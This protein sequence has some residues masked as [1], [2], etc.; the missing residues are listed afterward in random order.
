MNIT[1]RTDKTTIP[2]FL[3]LSFRPFFLGGALFSA[4]AIMWWALYFSA[5]IPSSALNT[6]HP[7]G[8]AIW[9]HGHEM[10]FGFG[11]AIIAGFL[12]TAVQTWTRVP[13]IKGSLL[14]ALFA[15]WLTAR[16]IIFSPFG[17][18]NI[19]IALIDV[20]FLLCSSLAMA[21]PVFKIRQWRN[22]AFP[23]ILLL[24]A[25]MNTVAH[26]AALSENPILIQKSLYAGVLLITLIITIV[27]GRVIPFFTANATKMVRK[28]NSKLLDIASIL[29]VA[30]LVFFAI[31]GFQQTPQIIFI[32]ICLIGALA[33]TIRLARW[34]GQHSLAT[35]L[36]WSLHIAYSFIPLGMILLALWKLN[37]ISNLS[38]VFHCFTA[39]AM[40]TMIISMISRVSLGHTGRPLKVNKTL[41][42][43]FV[44]IILSAVLR[45]SIPIALPEY[46]Q[47][48]IMASGTLWAISFG[49]F[50]VV[51]FPILTSPRLDGGNG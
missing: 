8:G 9:W 17:I 49:L 42:L 30:L 37:Y 34:G 51:Y 20:S 24:M 39:G 19:V 38:A 15:L 41:V 43:A 44:A 10:T 3:R 46:T 32:S 35:P 13:S 12:L 36:L 16:V 28:P 40:G 47:M 22:A 21:Y 7:H 48:A 27:G 25:G 33:H 5:Y 50:V 14:G 26:Y 1:D 29:S 11:T 4:L 2:P 18:P 6:W 31:S 23:I 45:I